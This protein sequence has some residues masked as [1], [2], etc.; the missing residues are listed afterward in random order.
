MTFLTI[1]T[2][3]RRLT[4]KYGRKQIWPRIMHLRKVLPSMTKRRIAFTAVIATA[5]L[6][7]TGVAATS[8]TAAAKGFVGVILPDAASSIRW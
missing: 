8:A 3:F 5:A 6:T 1:P 7:L 2:T 4:R